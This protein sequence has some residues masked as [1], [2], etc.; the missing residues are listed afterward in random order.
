MGWKWPKD[1]V[2]LLSASIL[3]VQAFKNRMVE[4]SAAPK[5]IHRRISS[6]S[7]FYKFLAGAGAELRLPITVPN[8]AH[9]QFISREA[10]DAV[11]ETQALSLARARQLLNIAKGDSILQIRD[12]ANLRFYVFTR[13]RIAR[14][15]S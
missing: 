8:P 14:A 1:S 11:D 13:G 10:S 2:E 9:A 12:R 7:S 4:E 6:L 15:A 3:D 5:T